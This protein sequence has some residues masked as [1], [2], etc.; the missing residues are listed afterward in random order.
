MS[1]PK[2]W[3]LAC[4]GLCALAAALSWFGTRHIALLRQGELLLDDF[5][6][7]Y[8]APPREQH[9]DIVV[10]TI[11]EETLTQFPF[12]SPINRRLIADLVQTLAERNVRALGIDL[13]F[14]QPTNADDDRALQAALDAFGAPTIIAIGDTTNGLTPRQLA[15]QE[16]FLKGRTVG[17]AGMLMTAGVVRHIYP[18]EE[19]SG[20][21]QP[22]FAAALA[23]V[24]GVAPPT[25]AQELYYR[26]PK[27]GTPAIR[28][29]PAR[30]LQTLPPAWFT[31]KIVLLGADLP[32][33]DTFR[34]PLSVAQSGAT[35]AGIFIHAQALAQLIDGVE[36]PTAPMAI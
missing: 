22:S 23:E 24:V 1:A 31:G 34:T 28:N 16:E 3:L 13:I 4:G 25:A 26:L 32:N 33:Q 6:L 29:F 11:D 14:D 19:G 21:F 9:S 36:L 20:G 2:R 18:G 7:A 12:R 27:D 8:F 15:F 10:L 30:H 35:M 5:R 17:L